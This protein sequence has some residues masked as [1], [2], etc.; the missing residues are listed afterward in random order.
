MKDLNATTKLR[1]WT[2]IFCLLPM[3]LVVTAAS[4]NIHWAQAPAML[5]L[6]PCP[7][8]CEPC[9]GGYRAW[10]VSEASDANN[11]STF[12]CGTNACNGC[13]SLTLDEAARS[14]AID[15]AESGGPDAIY[16]LLQ[17]YPDDVRLDT[18]RNAIQIRGC[19]GMIVAH[20]PLSQATVDAV[21]L[22]E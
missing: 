3:V 5:S 17:Q 13:P 6:P 8:Y 19:N 11:D 18:D 21:L 16:E 7:G 4:P 14:A 22:L 9:E 15:V 12:F 1:G 2:L 10:P 20:I